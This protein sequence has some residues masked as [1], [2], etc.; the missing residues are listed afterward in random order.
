MTSAV[1]PI[2]YHAPVLL[3]WWRALVNEAKGS[4]LL[5]A[6]APT[7]RPRVVPEIYVSAGQQTTYLKADGDVAWVDFALELTSRSGQTPVGCEWI[8]YIAAEFEDQ[9]SLWNADGTLCPTT[10]IRS[11]ITSRRARSKFTAAT[12]S[13]ITSSSTVAIR[14]EYINVR[15]S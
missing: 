7:V 4:T 12:A 15:L 9:I 5:A 10:K 3:K 6:E 8:I 14:D 11:A 2:G 13:S 1:R